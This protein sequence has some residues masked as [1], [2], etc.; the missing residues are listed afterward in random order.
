[1]ILHI[2]LILGWA[3]P[4]F[5]AGDSPVREP[6]A[7]EYQHNTAQD[8]PVRECAATP[9]SDATD[10]GA[11]MSSSCWYEE[12][13]NT[14]AFVPFVCGYTPVGHFQYA[15]FKYRRQC[16]WAGVAVVCGSWE[17]AGWKCCGIG[18]NHCDGCRSE[19][20]CP[21]PLN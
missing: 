3:S 4:H 11:L 20:G 10:P 14:C 1:M 8:L 2:L 12:C 16:C 15:Y 6:A 17:E 7:V 9:T 19:Q 21:Y 18:P 13:G 5:A